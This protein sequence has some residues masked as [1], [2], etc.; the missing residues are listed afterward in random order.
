MLLGKLTHI[1]LIVLIA[2]LAIRGIV[3]N[4]YPVVAVFAFVTLLLVAVY[5]DDYIY[6]K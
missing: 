5:Y 2:I 3:L 6:K 1:V 4:E